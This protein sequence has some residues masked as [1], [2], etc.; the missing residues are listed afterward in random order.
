M[1]NMIVMAV[2][3]IGGLTYVGWA[4]EVSPEDAAKSLLELHSYCD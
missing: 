3:L 2:G 4:T 1:F